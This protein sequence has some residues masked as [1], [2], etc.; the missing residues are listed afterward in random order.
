MYFWIFE[1]FLKIFG[2]VQKFSEN[3]GSSLKLFLSNFASFE[4]FLKINIREPVRNLR[5]RPVNQ[6]ECRKLQGHIT[7]I[8]TTSNITLKSNVIIV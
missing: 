3:F 6:S 4:N 8:L 1:N 7:I 2:R 5:I